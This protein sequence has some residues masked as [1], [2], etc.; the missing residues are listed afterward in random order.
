MTE[1][2]TRCEHLEECIA[3]SN[4]DMASV[5]LLLDTVRHGYALLDWQ[6]ML[7]SAHGIKQLLLRLGDRVAHIEAFAYRSREEASET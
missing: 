2:D 3:D 5:G 1:S 7:D 6:A 4:R